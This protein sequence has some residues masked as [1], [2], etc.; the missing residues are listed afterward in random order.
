V[1][2]DNSKMESCCVSTVLGGAPKKRLWRY[3]L[4]FFVLTQPQPTG[5]TLA[6]S[7]HEPD[8]NSNVR[9]VHVLVRTLVW[10]RGAGATS[11]SRRRRPPQPHQLL[12][13]PTVPR[14]KVHVEV[15]RIERGNVPAVKFVQFRRLLLGT[16]R[17]DSSL[18]KNPTHN[19]KNRGERGGVRELDGTPG[20]KEFF[21][22]GEGKAARTRAR[23]TF[24]G[25][26]TLEA[27]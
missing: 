4:P 25:C 24:P 18:Q 20:S 17:R 12:V 16:S 10:M 1:M 15:P 23:T 27:W 9:F 21:C 26:P 13:D 6:F 19:K 14:S 11:L 7:P 5:P 2:F 22:G 8:D 3:T